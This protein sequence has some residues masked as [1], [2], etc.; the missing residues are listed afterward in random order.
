M[1]VIS[2][3]PVQRI[4]SWSTPATKPCGLVLKMISNV[5]P[6]D[7]CRNAPYSRVIHIFG[8]MA[9]LY[10]WTAPSAPIATTE[11]AAA[12]IAAS[13]L[14]VTALCVSVPAVI[15]ASVAGDVESSSHWEPL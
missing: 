14:G 3:R 12:P 10:T 1:L 7:V 5:V 13:C 8:E 4:V 11:P 6:P 15:A 9:L 2:F